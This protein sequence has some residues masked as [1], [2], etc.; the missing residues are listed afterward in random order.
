VI[1]CVDVGNSWVKMAVA[2]ESGVLGRE[3]C[4][5]EE[6]RRDAGGLE[7]A[8][9]RSTAAVL[10]VH[11]AV[12]CSVVPEVTRRVL[13]CVGGVVGV[14]P[15]LVTHEMRFPMEIAVPLPSRVGVDRLCAAAG[16][17]GSRRR[18]AI[19]ADAGSAVTVDLVSDGKYL[20]GP[21]FAGPDAALG[22]LHARTSQLPPI[23]FAEQEDHWPDSS[24]TTESAMVLGTSLGTVGA[25]REAARHLERHAGSRP[26]RFL[27]GGWAG[28]LAAR[29]GAGWTVDPDLSV[30]GLFRVAQL[31]GV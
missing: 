29:M 13:S 30:R 5:L 11:G 19:V 20:G 10:A 28:V 22:A 9:R 24:D 1:L 25:V 6:V 2:E 27:T 21:I 26:P 23:D 15:V 4:A 3:R 17:L 8:V 12:V 18:H 16:A 31:N 14:R 7:L